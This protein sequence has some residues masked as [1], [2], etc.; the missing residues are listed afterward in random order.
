MHSGRADP[1]ESCPVT[2]PKLQSI[3]SA[4]SRVN[5]LHTVGLTNALPSALRHRIWVLCSVSCQ[6]WRHL[7]RSVDHHLMGNKLPP[8]YSRIGQT[9]SCSYVDDVDPKVLR[10]IACERLE[11]LERRLCRNAGDQCHRMHPWS[12]DLPLKRTRFTSMW[13]KPTSHSG[14]RQH[15]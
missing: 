13:Q 15:D 4:R 5:L 9:R 2:E 12:N 11:Q 10:Y 14:D 1:N 7:S 3:K 6:W 8:K